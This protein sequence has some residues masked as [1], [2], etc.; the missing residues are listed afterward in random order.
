MQTKLLLSLAAGSLLLSACGS[1]K[2]G[3]TPTPTPAAPV[4]KQEP[5]L[6]PANNGS[7]GIELWK[8][9]GTAD[10]T[11]MVKDINASGDSE[12]KHFFRA[13]KLTYFIADDGINDERLWVSNG[14]SDGTFSIA[15]EAE[16]AILFNDQLF[17]VA[18]DPD[19]TDNEELWKTDGTVAGTVKVKEIRPGSDGGANGNFAVVGDTL[20]FNANDGTNGNELWKTDGTTAGT[21]MAANIAPGAASSNPGDL[22]AFGGKV[23]FA[24]DDN[25]NGNELWSYDGNTATLLKDIATGSSSSGPLGNAA[26]LGNTLFFSANDRSTNGAELW[27][28]DGTAAGTVIAEDIRSGTSDSY[29]ENLTVVDNTLFFTANNGSNGVELWKTDGTNTTMVKNINTASASPRPGPSAVAP[30]PADQSSSPESLIGLGGKLYFQANNGTDRELWVSD[31]TDAGTTLLKNINATASSD[32]YHLGYFW[33]NNR[34]VLGVNDKG[35]LFEATSDDKGR[36]LWISDGTTEGTV[37]V[38]DINPDAG[39]GIRGVSR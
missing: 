13:S 16:D 37:L 9:E 2:S 17:F 14:T 22:I 11:V 29:P 3:S 36:E 26:V 12:P 24:A 28:T 10:T 4:E 21:V 34:E 35:V 7:N 18:G 8:T 27:K 38:K 15:P 31:G 19:D 30:S 33:Y 1:G 32:P 20:Y 39:N 5:F 25:T 6:F 23:L